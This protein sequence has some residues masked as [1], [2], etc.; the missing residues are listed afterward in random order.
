M[1]YAGLHGRG[2]RAC[3]DREIKILPMPWLEKEHVVR[4]R[5]VS[6]IHA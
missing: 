1:S 5:K 2:W 3:R 6:T 4:A